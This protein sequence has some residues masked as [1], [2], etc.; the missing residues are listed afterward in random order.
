MQSKGKYRKTVLSDG[1][2]VISERVGGFESISLGV[3]VEVGSR[4]ETGARA[5]VSH[6]LEHMVFKGTRTRSAEA[7]ALSLESLGG[8]LNAFTGREQT[9]YYARVLNRH[10][11]RAIDVL[12]DLVINPRLTPKDIEKER[13]VISEEIL[14]LED[15]PTEFLHDLFCE[16][17]WIDHPIGRPIM[18][19]VKTVGAIS[20]QDLMTHL[21][22]HYAPPKIVVAASGNV[23]HNGLVRL[24]RKHCRFMD[25]TAAVSGSRGPRNPGDEGIVVSATT[26]QQRSQALARDLNQAHVCVGSRAMPFRDKRRYILLVLSNLLGGGMSSRLFQAVREKRGLVYSIYSFHDFFKDTGIF[27]V[28]FGTGPQQT[29]QASDLVFAELRKVKKRRLD[30]QLLRDVKNQIKGNLTLSMEAPSNRM[31]RMAR[32]ELFVQQYIPLAHTMAA[33]ERVTASDIQ[34]FANELFTEQNITVSMLG[35]VDD[36]T[37]GKLDWDKLR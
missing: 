8:A 20:R 26:A 24:V 19:T 15:S 21:R 1:L 17:L 2:R 25:G 34:D 30:S 6:F 14:D 27:G 36:Q 9:C 32:H 23:D 12:A 37:I 33:I 29:I 5:G 11:P 16:N 28:Y 7:I 18:G 3:W 31:H 13:K 4:H 35:A 10:L 22:T